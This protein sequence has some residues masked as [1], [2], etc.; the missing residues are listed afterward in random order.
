MESESTKTEDMRS[1]VDQFKPHRAFRLACQFLGQEKGMMQ[2][3]TYGAAAEAVET[4][5]RLNPMGLDEAYKSLLRKL[6][7]SIIL[8]LDDIDK[9]L[10]SRMTKEERRVMS[11]AHAAILRVAAFRVVVGPLG[12]R[13]TLAKD[14][15]EHYSYYMPLLLVC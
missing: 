10:A 11:H 9:Y 7:V 4:F 2:Q 5:V 12:D 13:G 15:M 3:E 8:N 6:L 1:A 14:G